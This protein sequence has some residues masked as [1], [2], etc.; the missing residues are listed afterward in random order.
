MSLRWP[1]PKIERSCGPVIRRSLGP[2]VFRACVPVP[3]RLARHQA[4]RLFT[5]PPRYAGRRTH[6]VDARRN[7]RRGQTHA[8]CLAGG[9]GMGPPRLARSRLGWTRRATGQLC[10]A[11]A[12]AGYRA[13]WFDQPGHGDNRRSAVA[14]ADFVRAVEALAATHGPF[15]AT[16]GHLLGAAALGMAL[17]R[18]VRSGASFSSA[19]RRRST[20]MRITSRA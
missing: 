2:R 13:V 19:L 16:I 5:L 18:G 10:R 17:R 7:R 9:A 14:L 4:E 12:R 8:P 3:S 1:C 11:T 15:A 6:P 20:S